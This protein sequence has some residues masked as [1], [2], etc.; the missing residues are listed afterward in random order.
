[1]VPTS[2]IPFTT[3]SVPPPAT[4]NDSTVPPIAT[5]QDAEVA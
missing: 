1:L 5:E 3:A 4:T 2:T